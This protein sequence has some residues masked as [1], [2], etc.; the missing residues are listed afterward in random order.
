M[1]T[2]GKRKVALEA[3]GIEC[4]NGRVADTE[5]DRHTELIA[6]E[7]QQESGASIHSKGNGQ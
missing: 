5:A 4:V 7:K 2:E 1:D 3:E 6:A